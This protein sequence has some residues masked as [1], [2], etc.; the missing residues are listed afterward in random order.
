MIQRK[1]QSM[2][3]LSFYRNEN[4][5][6]NQQ[7]RLESQSI[8]T[9]HQLTKDA[10]TQD[11]GQIDD[12][13]NNIY[14][15]RKSPTY[16]PQINIQLDNLYLAKTPTIKKEFPNRKPRKTKMAPFWN[17]E[18]IAMLNQSV[19]QDLIT[20][21]S[22]DQTQN[23][24]MRKND[25][26][27]SNI[28]IQS[29]DFK[30][31]SPI[32]EQSEEKEL[33]KMIEQKKRKV[34]ILQYH[35][36]L[37]QKK[38]KNINLLNGSRHINFDASFETKNNMNTTQNPYINTQNS[39]TANNEDYNTQNKQQKFQTPTY[40]AG[41][42]LPGKLVK[43]HKYSQSFSERQQLELR[44][45]LF[46]S[47][48]KELIEDVRKLMN[49]SSERPF[50]ET[51]MPIYS[52]DRRRIEKDIII[53]NYTKK[54][55]NLNNQPQSQL[56]TGQ[57]GKRRNILRLNQ[58]DTS[59]LSQSNNLVVGTAG[60]GISSVLMTDEHIP[61]SPVSISQELVRRGAKFTNTF[62]N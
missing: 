56:T 31:A 38:G 39:T 45:N 62:K 54:L 58:F 17:E 22:F 2:S 25:I 9:Q 30:P 61:I 50:E 60:T 1:R 53:Q 51:G 18:Y 29:Q 41:S 10:F 20:N 36:L 42:R 6:K 28:C 13:T 19:Q 7:P 59:I 57:Q 33:P 49:Q 3:N 34:P 47:V 43:R 55:E 8:L 23:T 40:Y 27:F 32:I 26:V 52:K 24:F 44:K 37:N 11:N 35:G 4:S 48:N 15:R 14:T 16:L 5:H 21:R 12:Y 46:K